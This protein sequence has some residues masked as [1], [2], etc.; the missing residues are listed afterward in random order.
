MNT[1]IQKLR[2]PVQ[3]DANHNWKTATVLI[4]RD[5]NG[6]VSNP[7]CSVDNTSWWWVKAF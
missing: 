7:V 2:K 5:H 3:S 4:N 1:E 6:V